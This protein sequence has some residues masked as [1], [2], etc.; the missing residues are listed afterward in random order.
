MAKGLFA[1]LSILYPQKVTREY[2]GK[3]ILNDIQIQNE[4]LQVKRKQ[5]CDIISKTRDCYKEISFLKITLYTYKS[6][7]EHT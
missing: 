2:N 7:L 6:L 1:I 3:I 5:R 4:Y